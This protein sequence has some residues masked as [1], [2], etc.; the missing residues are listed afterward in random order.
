MPILGAG[1]RVGH[2]AGGA[3]EAGC[4]LGTKEL[5]N[6]LRRLH[7]AISR[8]RQSGHVGANA[9]HFVCMA[10]SSL[11]LC[12]FPVFLACR[13]DQSE[14]CKKKRPCCRLRA[15]RYLRVAKSRL[16]LGMKQGSKPQRR[17][18][19][20]WLPVSSVFQYPCT[21]RDYKITFRPTVFLFPIPLWYS[22][23]PDRSVYRS[24][25]LVPIMLRFTH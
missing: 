25:C 18:D 21:R 4:W 3:K 19:P 13:Q 12:Q 1:H 24:G 8:R 23:W 5:D 17:F 20:L 14:T 22:Y 6:Y 7:Q 10:A 15:V 11:L 9:W 16:G 2:C